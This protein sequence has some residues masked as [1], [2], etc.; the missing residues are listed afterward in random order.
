METAC[1]V[2][3][4]DTRSEEAFEALYRCTSAGLLSM[5]LHLC[6]RRRLDP[7]EL[8]QDTYVNVYRYAGGFDETSGAGFRGWARA[9]ATNVVRRA[10]RRPRMLSL[11]ALPQGLEEPLDVRAGPDLVVCTSEQ[12]AA[13]R[14]AWVLLLLHYV[15]GVEKLCA[16]DRY[17]LELI[18]VQGLSYGEAGRI[19]RVRRS[20]MKMIMFRS[21]RRLREHMRL[22]MGESRLSCRRVG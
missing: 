17:A 10:S 8:L 4:R 6:A 11:A 7:A 3:F 19:L 2:R 22:A 13:L 1:M 12:S 5:I 14:Q 9:I 16:R 15:R 20:N 21:R 18:E